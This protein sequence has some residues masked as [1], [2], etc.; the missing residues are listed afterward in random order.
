MLE[1]DG[2]V[3]L[4]SERKSP[5]DAVVGDGQPLPPVI[6]LR[7]DILPAVLLHDENRFRILH[8]PFQFVRHL[9]SFDFD[10]PS[11]FPQRT[12]V[13]CG[14]VGGGELA[15]LLLDR[16][17]CLGRSVRSSLRC[18]L[19]LVAQSGQRADRCREANLEL[20][21]FVDFPSPLGP[22]RVEQTTSVENRFDALDRVDRDAGGQ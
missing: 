2:R 18:S 22:S 12:H 21:P 6:A 14:I 16:G 13:Q 17:N 7:E 15:D 9:A 4:G 19:Q 5:E 1:D 10:L 20:I 11:G 8:V 3:L